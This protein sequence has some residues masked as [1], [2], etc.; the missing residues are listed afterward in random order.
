MGNVTVALSAAGDGVS[1]ILNE[2]PRHARLKK[3]DC[4]AR[5]EKEVLGEVMRGR[6]IHD[7]S[8]IGRA[9]EKDTT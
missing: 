9:L 5:G 8:G 1:K 3:G 4:V 6:V 7:C 2:V